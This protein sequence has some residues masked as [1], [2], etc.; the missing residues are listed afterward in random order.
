MDLREDFERILQ[1][2]GYNVLIVREDTKVRCSCWSEKTQESPRSCP[3]C[4]G[5]GTVPKI[6]KHTT[7]MQ[8]AS[9]PISYPG[10]SKRTE[11]GDMAVPGLAYFFKHDVRLS[12]GDLI[13]EVDWSSSNKPTYEG[14]YISS[15]SHIDNKRWRGGQSAYQKA[16]TEDEPFQKE[17]RGIRIV[18]VN[19]IK[20]YEVIGG[21]FL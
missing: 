1:D 6:E 10:M 9:V 21:S 16:Y 4:F 2:F 17:C 13:V 7:R 5:L 19:G 3:V 12:I 15:V 8:D 11:I 18:D 14:G 20:N